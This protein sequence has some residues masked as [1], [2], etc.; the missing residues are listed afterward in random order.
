LRINLTL[1]CWCWKKKL[2]NKSLRVD[3]CIEISIELIL[4]FII[5]PTSTHIY[6][7]TMKYLKFYQENRRELSLVNWKILYNTSVW[8]WW[9]WWF[10]K[11]IKSKVIIKFQKLQSP[12]SNFSERNPKSTKIKFNS[13]FKNICAVLCEEM[14]KL[15]IFVW[16]F[17]V[18]KYV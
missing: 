16:K 2:K 3:G 9:W 7:L 1:Y 15:R 13:L 5:T 18:E 6:L 17:N 8:W 4:I 14:F 12:H 10:M 11:N